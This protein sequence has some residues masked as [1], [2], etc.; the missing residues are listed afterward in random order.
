VIAQALC[1]KAA[2]IMEQGDLSGAEVLLDEA[3][4]LARETGPVFAMVLNHRAVLMMKTQHDDAALSLL[5]QADAVTAGDGLNAGATLR[6][7]RGRLM[8]KTGK[9]PEALLLFEQALELDRQA[10]F[11]RGMA[12]DLSAMAGIHEQLGEDESAL[13]CLDRSIKIYALLENREK[14][15]E[16][17]DRLE[18]LALKTGTDVRVTVHFA[19]QWLAGKAVDAICQ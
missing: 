12:D 8:L 10:G 13:D 11:S 3:Q 19:N 4:L 9:V 18:S 14:V 5:D 17:L 7:T 2:T 15:M 16:Y 6:F 1:N